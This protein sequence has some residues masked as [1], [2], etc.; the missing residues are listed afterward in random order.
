MLHPCGNW[1]PRTPKQGSLS[2]CADAFCDL[3]LHVAQAL[4]QG[5]KRGS[6][7]GVERDFALKALE[8]VVVVVQF[9]VT[10]DGDR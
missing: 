5:E 4:K 3:H 10:R 8:V 1:E 2:G 6:W 9:P 7:A